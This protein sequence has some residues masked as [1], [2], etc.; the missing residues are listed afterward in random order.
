MDANTDYAIVQILQGFLGRPKSEMDAL[1]KEQ[2]QFNCPGPTCRHDMDKYNLEYNAK[3][4]M[5][6]CWKCE[7]KYAGYVYRLVGDYGSSS[8]LSR[9]KVLL[10][11]DR[12]KKLKD[13]HSKKPKID[14]NLITCKLP[15]GYMPLGKKK[16]TNLYKLA[17][18]YLV[19]TRKVSPSMIDKYEIGY[20]E[21]GPRRFR[22]I[23]PS[24]NSLGRFNYYEARSY[25]KNPDIP[26]IKP[27]SK[28]VAK[29]DIIFNEYFINWDLPIFLIEGV[30]D[31]FR[32]PNAIPIL[33]KEISNLLTNELLKHNSTVI[34]CF[35][36]DAIKK[37]EETYTK[38]SSLGLNVFF[39]D[40][41]QYNMNYVNK[42]FPN[43]KG[44]ERK[45]ALGKDISKIYEDY[46]K[47]EVSKAVSN[48]KRLDFSMQVAKK[49]KT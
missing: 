11:P 40:L 7:P 14:H 27:S 17:W 21:T 37:T 1:A 15:D 44:E 13:Q 29:N 26:Y 3:K 34:V 22:I 36:P 31:M 32:L 49:L 46:G 8:D 9:L 38:L 2:W 41:V 18:D 5:F 10:P 30:F 48:I 33:G 23:I 24:K 47:E 6:K 19:N 16:N 43:I 25:M 20:T 12:V 42:N 35:D 45:R 28:E 39:V 4:K